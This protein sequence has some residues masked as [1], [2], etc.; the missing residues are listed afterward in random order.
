[1]QELP[2][3]EQR[4]TVTI[5]FCDLVHST[6]L[7]AGDPETYRRV[8][9]RYF[10]QMRRIVERHG[11]TVEKF[12]GD[13]VMA[14][15]GVPVAHEDDALRSVRAA[16]EMLAGLAALNEE[17]DPSLGLR[18]QARIGIN[19]GEVLAGD[20]VKG[21][22]FVAG[23][24]V[25]I[26]K[27]LEQ[28]AEASEILIGSATYPLVAHAV[29][30]GA[31][32]RISVKGKEDEIGKHRVDDVRAEAP[33]LAR[34]LNAPIVGRDEELQQLQRAF[35]RAVEEN[36]CRLFTLLGPPGIGKSRLATELLSWVEGRAATSVGRCLSYG[37]GITFWPLAEALR[38]LGG[39]P[40]LREALS[41]DDQGDAVVELL[42]G[43]TGTS[44]TGS[45]EQI[46]WAVRRAFEAVARR[47]PFVVCLEDLHWAEPTMLD[48]VEYIV[49]WIRDAP[50]LVVALARPELIEDR[51]HWMAR[52]PGYETLTL[53]PLSRA[54]TEALLAGLSAEAPLSAEVRERIAS[55]AEG[56][57]L[58]VEQM[59]AMA[60][61][62]GGE[63]TIPPSIQAL[64]AERLDR[65]NAEERQVIERA[66]VVGRDFPVAAVASLLPD[67][68][69]GHLTP[70]L[71]ALVRKEFIRP[72]P[73]PSPGGDRFSFQH[74]LVRDAAYEAIPKELRAALHEQLA[75]WMDD[76]GS[77]REPDE[78]L[79]YHLE[80][81]YGYRHEV[82]LL[83]E[84][85]TRVRLRASE[86]LAAGGSRALGRNDV[87]AGLK[88]LDRAVALRPEDD[89]AVGLRLDLAQAL[90]Q[91]GKLPDAGEVTAE[92]EARASG[93]GDEVGA[94]R[95]QLLGAR[96]ASHV[97]REGT[98]SEGT[99]AD[100]LA[101]AEEARPV[102]ARAGDELALAEAW[103]AIAYAQLI[104][105][106]YAAM[107]EA[108]EHALEH[109]RS[110][111][112]TR[113][114]GE[115]PAWQGTAM[116]YGP[117]PVDEALRWYEEQQAQHP[118]ALTQ[119]AML[120]AMRGNFDRARGLV[121][122]ADAAA[123]EFGPKLYLAAG[124]MALWEIETLAGDA[125]AAEGAVRP[126]C[127]LLEELGEVGYR[128]MAVCQL[129]ASL[130]ALQR[131]DEAD[132][133]SRGAEASAPTDDVSSQMLWR[134]VRAQT[135]A[136]R[137]ERVE[138][139]RLGREAVSLAAETDMLNFHG[140]ALADLG[141][142]YL[143][144]GRAEEARGQLEQALALYER[145]GNIVAAAKARR[146]LE[147]LAHAAIP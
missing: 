77:G 87:Q 7:A 83:D 8:Q 78:L 139:E 114:D 18:L 70:Q 37:E 85:T 13:E 50:I 121:A 138:A 51:P 56:N 6:G 63:L 61:E 102:F 28:A 101:V 33:T 131:L 52:Q 100:L 1:L 38:G 108:V 82:G 97:Q 112:S 60:A 94:L 147:E 27:R 129:A 22:A 126:S 106:R 93:S 104:R 16:K 42:R 43:V 65:L 115:L 25:I 72:D 62:E 116:F 86:L 19:T 74:V 76:S 88:L 103:M 32:E 137:G 81:A 21:H 39:E 142:V 125:S 15:F 49:G 111:G 9:A 120:E 46:F 47:R 10:E 12:V 107:L 58:F 31:L 55:A 144:G 91:S 92:I 135:L 132:E 96:I 90:L 17:L 20:P 130:C 26:A 40:S 69:R 54:T 143:L 89:P 44:E 146:R 122:S 128:Y 3:H 119:R 127:E 71:F 14:V 141:E 75:D 140:N 110:A 30:A 34:R 35:E 95:A 118:I 59:S 68:Q 109:A 29:E 64:L 11:G 145:K 36:C 80:Q 124:G 53:R 123:E 66:S 24:P 48:L 133:W 67:E 79:G 136:R 5:L 113:W 99:S 84:H 105:C 134:Q 2:R 73:T 4:K 41:D 98:G 117:T 45:S 23:E 57:P